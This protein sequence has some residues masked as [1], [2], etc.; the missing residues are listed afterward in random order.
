MADPSGWVDETNIIGQHAKASLGQVRSKRGLALPGAGKKGHDPFSAADRAC[1]QRK[2]PTLLTKHYE[3]GTQQVS[4][5]IEWKSAGFGAYDD[6]PSVVD[7]VAS[8]ALYAQKILRGGSEAVGVEFDGA[9]Q[10]VGDVAQAN[11]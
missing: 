8:N 9:G 11:M 2:Q 1:M 7:Q 5:H 10:M 3:D 4:P 6:L